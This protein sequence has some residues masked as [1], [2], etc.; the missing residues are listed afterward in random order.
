MLTWGDL[1]GVFGDVAT[2]LILVVVYLD[3][4]TPVAVFS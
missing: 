1:V 4:Y 3:P 2:S